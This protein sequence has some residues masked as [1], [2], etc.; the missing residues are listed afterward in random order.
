MLRLF[1]RDDCA[2]LWLEPANE[3]HLSFRSASVVPRQPEAIRSTHVTFAH[4]NRH[5]IGRKNV[6][7]RWLIIRRLA[8]RFVE[9]VD[10]QLAIDEDRLLS[11]FFVEQHSATKA[12]LRLLSG[13]CHHRIGPRA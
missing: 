13:L 11:I 6:S 12:S 4:V 2:P 10:D 9:R 3:A 1:P 5:L 7:P 8:I